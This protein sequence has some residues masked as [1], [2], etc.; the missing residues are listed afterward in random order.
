MLQR[1]G[2]LSG[3]LEAGRRTMDHGS[4]GSVF[5]AV[6]WVSVAAVSSRESGKT[7]RELVSLGQ[8]LASDNVNS[9][10]GAQDA[11]G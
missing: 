9:D 4:R 3:G 7:N 2:P 10:S 8:L 1:R 6:A 11:I 5:C